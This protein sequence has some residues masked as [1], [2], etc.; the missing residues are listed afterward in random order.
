MTFSVR[1]AGAAVAGV[2]AG[3][4]A[5]APNARF[6]AATQAAATAVAPYT[7]TIPGTSVTFD[8]VPVPGGAFTM[9]SPATGARTR[10]GR[11]PAG[12]GH[13]AHFWMGAREVTWAEYDLYAFASSKAA[14]APGADPAARGRGEQADVRRTPTSRGASERGNSRRSA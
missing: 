12:P 2:A 3:V 7:E 1:V 8:M 11:R 10:R 4:M 6:G 5:A 13:V 14:A 9:G